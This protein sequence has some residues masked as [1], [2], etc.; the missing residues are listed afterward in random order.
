MLDSRAERSALGA[1]A[2]VAVVDV[3]MNFLSPKA[4]L[5]NHTSKKMNYPS[6][7][8]AQEAS[9][10]F[11]PRR[12]IF[13]TRPKSEAR[14]RIRIIISLQGCDFWLGYRTLS[15]ELPTCTVKR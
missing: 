1:A 8:S 12:F 11:A 5:Q 2:D 9:F 7:I 15:Q 10:D 13:A 14:N 3:S 6:T 4:E